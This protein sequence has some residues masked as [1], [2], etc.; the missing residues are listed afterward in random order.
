M[1]AMLTWWFHDAEGRQKFQHYRRSRVSTP[2]DPRTKTYGYR[3]LKGHNDWDWSK[4]R[5]ADALIYRLPEVLANPDARLVLTE[6]ERDADAARARGVLA[7]SHHGGAGK[8]TQAMAE[9][10]AEHRGNIVLVADNDVPGAACVCLRY[11]LLRGVG[12]PADR[13]RVREVVPSHDGADLRDHLEAGYRFKDLRRAD[14]GR[15]REVAQTPPER[16][17]ASTQAQMHEDYPGLVYEP[18]FGWVNKETNYLV[19]AGPGFHEQIE[20]WRPQSVPRRR[21]KGRGQ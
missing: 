19:F 5:G 17:P 3:F 11:D 16:L 1:S 21:S 8:F 10:L 6:G 14:L 20:K 18:D 13:L 15:L 4:P 9:S 12:I 2:D 7:S